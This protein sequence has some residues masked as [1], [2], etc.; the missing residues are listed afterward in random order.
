MNCRPT[1]YSKHASCSVRASWF[2][3]D[4]TAMHRQ[5]TATWSSWQKSLNSSPCTLHLKEIQS[6]VT[7]MRECPLNAC[8][9]WCRS[10][11]AEHREASQ[12]RQLFT[13]TSVF[14]IQW[15]HIIIEGD[16]FSGDA[17]AKTSWTFCWR[18]ELI[19]SLRS[20]GSRIWH[21]GQKSG[22]SVDVLG[23]SMFQ[24]AW[25]QVWQKLCPHGRHT[26]SVK[27]STQ[28]GHFSSSSGASIFAASTVCVW[29]LSIN[30]SK[31]RLTFQCHFV[32]RVFSYNKLCM[33]I[34]ATTT[35]EMFSDNFGIL[36]CIT[37]FFF[38]SKFKS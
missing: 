5:Q 6:S 19:W 2:L 32:M 12:V 10:V 35:Y 16:P 30:I 17:S 4:P 7:S 22:S 34:N 14:P 23:S 9:C 31:K 36:I 27:T 20:G 21:S 8:L 25:M 29:W 38:R 33:S 28:T 26:G 37:S 3:C 24:T 15:S 11:W 18:S 1:L 13:A